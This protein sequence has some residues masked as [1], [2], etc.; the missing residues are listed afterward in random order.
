[1]KSFKVTKPL[2]GSIT[3]LLFVI[4]LCFSF[5][6]KQKEESP[7]PDATEQSAGADATKVNG[8]KGQDSEEE[9]QHELAEPKQVS[10]TSIKDDKSVAKETNPTAHEPV[11]LAKVNDT[12]I[13]S[14]D[15]EGKPL[16]MVINREILYQAGLK[17]GLDV[18]L[19][20]E[21]ENLKKKAIVAAVENE[22]LLDDLPKRSKYT[23]REI[24]NYYKEHIEKYQFLRFS[25][26]SVG[27][28]KLASE[29]HAKALAGESLE[30]IA[31]EMRKSGVNVDHKNIQFTRKYRN[32]FD[33]FAVGS[34]SD[35]FPEAN[36]FKVLRIEAVKAMP[37]KLAKRNVRIA[38]ANKEKQEA[39]QSKI[40]RLKRENGIEVT[41]FSHGGE[42]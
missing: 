1:M 25:E 29:I 26:I 21:I 32:L 27:D 16:D 28:E 9:N 6:C 17:Q 10:G 18:K 31:S 40:D 42:E 2:Y 22:I 12:E 11:L 7:G 14:T 23:D 8:D 37:L 5:A 36:S 4:M 41:I 34:V 39:L 15:L 3:V 13:Y 20:D 19:K 33:S 35:P 24:E 30:E 38:L